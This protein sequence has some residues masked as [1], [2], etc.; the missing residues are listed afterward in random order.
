MENKESFI[1][2]LKDL[3]IDLSLNQSQ[4]AN[5]IGLK[6]SQVSEWLSGK[7]KPGYD[8]LKLICITFGISADRLLGLE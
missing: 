7:S 1:E 6:Q 8:N 4:F 2:I 5:K 3:M